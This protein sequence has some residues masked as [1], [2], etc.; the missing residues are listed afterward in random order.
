[1][2]LRLFPTLGVGKGTAWNA[3]SAQPAVADT[4]CGFLDE[5]GSESKGPPLRFGNV[6]LVAGE[7]A[8]SLT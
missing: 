4:E 7:G 3:K 6:G 1:M 5:R 8:F 2:L